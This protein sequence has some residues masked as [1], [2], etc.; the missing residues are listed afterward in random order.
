[1][2]AVGMVISFPPLIFGSSIAWWVLVTGL[3]GLLLISK[4]KPRL[5]E[6][7]IQ[8]KK[9]L[10]NAFNKKEVVIACILFLLLFATANL[11]QSFYS[12]NLRILA[13]IFQ[14]LSSPR[15]ILAFF[16]FIPFFLV[17]FVAEGMYLHE[18]QQ[19]KTGK[20]N[21]NGVANYTKVVFAKITP[22]LILIGLQYL[23]KL[24]F[25][26]WVFPSFIGFIAEFLWLIVP[27]FI[28]TSVSSTWFYKNTRNIATGAVFNTL[29]IAWITSVVFPF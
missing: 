13:P 9:T 26:I 21:W 22:F 14:E 16:A 7:R 4:D 28:I 6:N 11:L 10:K 18:L 20:G 12:I 1:M 29:I 19:T 3:M 23:P 17:Y 24:F 2:I 27:I 5:G 8:L 15:R 25:N